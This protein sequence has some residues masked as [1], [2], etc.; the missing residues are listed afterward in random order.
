MGIEQKVEEASSNVS[1]S[2]VECNAL[3]VDIENEIL[4]MHNFIR[5]NYGIKF[6]ELESIVHH[7]IDYASV[8]KN[9]GNQMDLTLI[10][11]QGL[12]PSAIIMVVSITIY[13][14]ISLTTTE[15]VGGFC[16]EG[17]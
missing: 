11:L 9:I 17:D 6:P 5:D 1:K 8:I 15:A 4:V 16:F 14:F 10:D 12:L 13:S 7:P 2:I 3:L